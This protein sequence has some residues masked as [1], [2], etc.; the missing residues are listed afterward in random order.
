MKIVVGLG[1]P[2]K[3]YKNTRHNFGFLVVDQVALD[4]QGKFKKSQFKGEVAEVS[5]EGVR[6]FLLKPQTY[7]NLSGEAVWKV[8]S[9]YKKKLSDLWVVHDDLDLELGRIKLGF[10]GAAGGHKGI[11]S[12]IDSLGSGDFN[13]VRLGIGRPLEKEDTVDYVLRPFAREE[14]DILEKTIEK[15]IQ[16]ILYGLSHGI[17]TAMNHFNQKKEI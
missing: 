1:N 17:E 14:K 6:L 15:A 9:F 3:E 2:G 8:L 16:A 4:L 5:H 11:Q 12:I 10:G 7:M 13:R